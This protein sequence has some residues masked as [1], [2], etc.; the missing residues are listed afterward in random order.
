TSFGSNGKAYPVVADAT[1]TGTTCVTGDITSCNAF[2]SAPTGGLAATGGTI[3]AARALRYPGAAPK[4]PRTHRPAPSASGPAATG[5]RLCGTQ[6]RR[7]SPSPTV[8]YAHEPPTHRSPAR[9][10]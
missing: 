10:D 7:Y 6:L 5:A 1:F 9:W 3:P 4:P 2:M 8:C